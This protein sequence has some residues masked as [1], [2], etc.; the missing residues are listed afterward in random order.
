MGSRQQVKPSNRVSPVQEAYLIGLSDALHIAEQQ[1]TKSDI[2]EAIKARIAECDPANCPE[3]PDGSN[4]QASVDGCDGVLSAPLPAARSP[5][6][7]A[8]GDA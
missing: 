5:L 3:T 2:L 1:T 7:S 8:G 6:P 4:G